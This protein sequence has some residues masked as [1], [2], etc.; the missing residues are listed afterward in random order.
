MQVKPRE[1]NIFGVATYIDSK[2]TVLYT[3]DF[4]SRAVGRISDLIAAQVH[5][6][7]IDELRLRAVLLLGIYQ[8]YAVKGEKLHTSF[9]AQ[10]CGLEVGLD[11]TTLAVAVSFHWDEGRIPMFEDLVERVTKGSYTSP[12]EEILGFIAL[13]CTQL[14]MKYEYRENRIELVMVYDL[15][16]SGKD[17]KDSFMVHEIHSET[18]PLLE[19]KTYI[20]L[21]DLDAIGL[22]KARYEEKV[23]KLKDNDSKSENSEILRGNA[24][25]EDDLEIIKP[26]ES[27][28]QETEIVSSDNEQDS[29]STNIAGQSEQ[30]PDELQVV[31]GGKDSKKNGWNLGWVKKIFSSK[32]AEQPIDSPVPSLP[33][34][35]IHKEESREDLTHSAQVETSAQ[36]AS[37]LQTQTDKLINDLSQSVLLSENPQIKQIL[38]EISSSVESNKASRWV[39]SLSTELIQEKAR[40]GS[41]S[42]GLQQEHRQKLQQFQ[43]IENSLKEEIKKRDSVIRRQESN[44]L[45]KDQ[46]I[47]SLTREKDTVKNQIT[48][49]SSD[50]SKAKLEQLQ[51]TAQAKDAE[52]RA[53]THKLKE[54]GNKLS[55]V[56]TKQKTSSDAGA[57]A[58]L[59]ATERK[60]EELKRI[61]QRLTESLNGQREKAHDRKDDQDL[62]RKAEMLERQS[63]EYKKQADRTV[64]RLKDVQDSERKLQIELSKAL[65]ENRKL[66]QA[67]SRQ[68]AS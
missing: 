63:I 14:I 66:R 53:L 5:G 44:L 48:Q 16:D 65:D 62:K 9:E 20:E 32:D 26:L 46:K 38:S 60:V 2:G 19:V 49:N 7:G 41:L 64:A 52:I 50:N 17:S 33:A 8:S 15:T 43:R 30:L 36:V 10:P 31:K 23:K 55:N 22:L 21:G 3:S 6:T 27:K 28:N 40:L 35:S 29:L 58:K 59:Q 54:L 68:K 25:H 24:H 34:E 18:A 39:E 4:R 57:V 1:L 61:N 47:S 67:Q 56:V 42:K 51:R 37:E 13:F 45:T 12:F 11:A